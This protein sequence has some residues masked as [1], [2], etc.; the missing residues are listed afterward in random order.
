MIEE[1]K[2]D[3]DQP[4]SV[5]FDPDGDGFY[6]SDDD[7][8]K[9]HNRIQVLYFIRKT[10]APAKNPSLEQMYSEIPDLSKTSDTDDIRLIRH[11]DKLGFTSLD[12]LPVSDT[13]AEKRSLQVCDVIYQ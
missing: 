12:Q 7:A 6:I 1:T 10:L 5:R 9:I 8:I 13:Y 2:E 3:P 11:L 4:R